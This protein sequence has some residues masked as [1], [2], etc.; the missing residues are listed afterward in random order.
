MVPRVSRSIR[1]TWPL[2]TLAA[3]AIAACDA[4]PPARWTELTTG[5]EF[6]RI[7]AGSFVMGSPGDE[8]G[9]QDD[10]L[11][12]TVRLTRAFDLS[13]RE[14]SRRQWDAVMPLPPLGAASEDVEA[15]VVNVS[16]FEAQGFVERLNRL[17]AGGFRLPTEAEWEYACRAGSV[18]A[19]ATGATLTTDEANYDGRFPASGQP[20]GARRGQPTRTGSFAPNAWGLHDMHG[21]VWEWVDDPYC[22][23]AGD[24]TDPIGT[25]PAPLKVIRGGSWRFDA[26]SARCALRYTHRPQDRGDSLGFRVARTHEP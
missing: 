8:P 12:H 25:C 7:P 21:N 24:A 15:P 19:Y 11:P 20:P 9:R 23:Y 1:A 16:W 22:P 14:V 4:A 2:G 3:I 5:L 6:V 13:A 10:E 26:N 18:T 17:T